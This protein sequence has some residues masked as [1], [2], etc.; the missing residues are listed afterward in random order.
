MKQ[1]TLVTVTGTISLKK[2]AEVLVKY[3]K[4]DYDLFTGITILVEEMEENRKKKIN[5]SK[6]SSR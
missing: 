6:S 3:K 1:E 5:D 2:I 4:G